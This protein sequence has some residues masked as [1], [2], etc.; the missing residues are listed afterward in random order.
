MR[1]ILLTLIFS[2]LG[3]VPLAAQIKPPD[4]SIM[5][6][7]YDPSEFPLWAMDIRRYEVIAIGS[8]PITYALAALVYDFSIYASN[9]FAAQYDLGTQRA[10]DDLRIII[11]SAAAMSIVLATVDL[12]INISKRKASNNNEQKRIRSPSSRK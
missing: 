8:F 1:L 2:L 5:P 7:E 3:I 9:N 11:G 4:E 12:F 10:E 6:E